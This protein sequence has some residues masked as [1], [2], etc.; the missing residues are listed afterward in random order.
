MTGP[1]I[2][3]IRSSDI[4]A[5]PVHSLSPAHYHANGT[6]RCRGWATERIET[7]IYHGTIENRVAGSRVPYTEWRCDHH[8]PTKA[9]AEDCAIAELERRDS[10]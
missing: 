1:D 5:C 9:Q 7:V 2:K 10:Q 3:V 4:A 6:C 8:H